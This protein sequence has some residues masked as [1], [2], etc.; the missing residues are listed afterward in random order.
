MQKKVMNMTKRTQ[1]SEIGKVNFVDRILVNFSVEQDDAAVIDRGDDYQLMAVATMLEGIDFDLQYTPLEHLGYR[2]VVAAVSNIYAMNGHP[3]YLSLALGVSARFSV[4]EIE[5]LYSGIGRG[6][7]DYSVRLVGGDTSPSM[8]GLTLALSC[9]GDVS[10]ERITRRS[11]AGVTDLVC[12]SGNLGAAYMG[13][14]LLERE[15]RAVGQSG[16]EPLLKGH[17][18][19]L[20]RQLKPAARV[21]IVDQ[22]AEYD[23]LPTAM[24]DITRSTACSAL[25]LCRASGVGMRIYLDRLPIASE[26][27][28]MAEQMSIDPVVAALNGGDDYELM[29]TVPL[30]MHKS[31]LSMPGVDVIGHI[32]ES[33]KGAALTTPDGSEIELTSPGF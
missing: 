18:Y 27:F 25:H 12:V 13:L 15:K 31:V 3:R 7:E 14:Q 2:A 16:V 9:L 30:S 33:S 20:G 23:V 5:A 11:G 28:A 19:I 21:D 29:F 10:K 17:E 26:T 4:E 6:C 22:L 1:I 24:I 8:T 32:V